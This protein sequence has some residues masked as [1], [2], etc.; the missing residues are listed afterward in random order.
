MK[1]ARFNC[2]HLFLSA[3]G[4]AAAVLLIAALVLGRSGLSLVG[5]LGLVRA[6]FIGE[7]DADAVLDGAL[8]GMVDALGDR[9]SHYYDP[10]FYAELDQRHTNTYVGIGVVISYG[11]PRG[12]TI[13]AV[14]ADGPA[15][16]AG[17]RAGEIVTAVDGQSV[18]GEA[19]FQA[20]GLIQGEAGTDV[21]L[22]LLAP[23]GE[24]R[25]VTVG[26]SALETQPVKSELLEGRVGYVRLENFYQR[27]GKMV[28]DAVDELV[29]QGA[30][31]LIFDMRDNGGGYVTELTAM[32]DHL[33]PEGPIFRLEGRGGRE[34]VTTSDAKCVELPMAVLVNGNSYSAAEFFAA[35]LQEAAGA[36]IVGEP[37]SG[38][39]Y[40]QQAFEL[41]N[42]GALNISTSR[43]TTGEG[44]SL[45]GTGVELDVEAALSETEHALFQAGVLPYED[46]PQLQ[47]ALELF[48]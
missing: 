10:E 34:E 13:Q 12:V 40:S 11:D 7:Y 19:R 31:A 30:E 22:T 8:T 5:S 44:K 24:E 28:S 18:A 35:E 23:T 1:K 39:G 42:G 25:E 6:K 27:T 21:V 26:R 17:V 15:Q 32:L 46:D 2:I 29:A 38:K 48:R 33:L 45:V 20:A 14:Q 4:G 9:W 43:Y 36:K 37:T 3:L 16:A 47:A 41:P